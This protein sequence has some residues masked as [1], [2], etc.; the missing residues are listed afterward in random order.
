MLTINHDFSKKLKRM[1]KKSG[2]TQAELAKKLKIAN[3]TIGM[4]EQGRR[5]PDNATLSQLCQ[6]LDVSGDYMLNLS[7]DPEFASEKSDVYDI[8]SNFIECLEKQ[9][10]LMFNGQPINN[11]E[12]EKIISALKTATTL[13]M[14]DLDEE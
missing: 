6:I 12:K 10:N 1:R 4:Y 13:T 2:M 7:D 8:I 3:S 11:K 9:D 14:S 5:R